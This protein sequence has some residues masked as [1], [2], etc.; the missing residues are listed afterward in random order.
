MSQNYDDSKQ[1]K[2]I[3]YHSPDFGEV[4]QMFMGLNDADQGFDHFF[5]L[6][7]NFMMFVPQVL[8]SIR[9]GVIKT[10]VEIDMKAWKRLEQIWYGHIYLLVTRNQMN[11]GKVES[12]EILF[13]PIEISWNQE[14]IKLPA[15]Q[16]LN[17]VSHIKDNTMLIRIR[18]PVPIRHALGGL[19]YKQ[20]VLQGRFYWDYK[21]K[22]VPM[23][24]SQDDIENNDG[25][26]MHVSRKYFHWAINVEKKIFLRYFTIIYI[27]LH[28]II[29]E[30]KLG[31]EDD[32][33]SKIRSNVTEKLE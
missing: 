13:K 16:N 10:N 2:S 8:E 6:C 22:R 1:P 25:T 33:K 28:K 31:F 26:T 32:D 17:P 21:D 15:L 14:L 18:E 27:N 7:Q 20:V 4:L 9:Q 19:D 24:T 12:R 23:F 3:R 5:L 30:Q 11:I 29:N